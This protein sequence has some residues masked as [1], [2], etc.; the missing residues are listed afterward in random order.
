[1]SKEE[2]ELFRKLNKLSKSIKVLEEVEVKRIVSNGKIVIVVGKGQAARFIGKN[3]ANIKKLKKFLK[4]SIKVVEEDTDIK[5]FV[6]SMIF[7]I[8]VLGV[9]IM[10]GENERYII[11]I[12]KVEERNLPLRSNE[13]TNVCKSLFERDFEVRL[14]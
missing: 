6:Q 8:P 1:M 10:Y 12:P 2:V 4:K 3:G 5:T 14:E 9:N 7:P 13:I 11:R